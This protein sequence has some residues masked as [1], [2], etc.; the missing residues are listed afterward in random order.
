MVH[1]FLDINP[2]H[3]ETIT[4][5]LQLANI[6]GPDESLTLPEMEKEAEDNFNFL[7]NFFG[8]TEAVEMI[9][10]SPVKDSSNLDSEDSLELNNSNAQNESTW[11]EFAKYIKEEKALFVKAETYVSQLEKDLAV[12]E[13]FFDY[14]TCDKLKDI[15]TFRTNSNKNISVKRSTLRI[16]KVCVSM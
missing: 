14:F 5:F 10:T 4:D 6:T 9:Q 1:I 13:K 7:C 8:L 2:Q 3:F 11:C 12:D 15:V 16:F